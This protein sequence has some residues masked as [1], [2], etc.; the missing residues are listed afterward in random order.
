MKREVAIMKNQ[1]IY[2]FTEESK[3]EYI[4]RAVFGEPSDSSMCRAELRSPYSGKEY[5]FILKPTSPECHLV[6]EDGDTLTVYNACF[7]LIEDKN[8]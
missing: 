4:L 6:I 5:T 8:N 1:G 7:E 2:R 3:G